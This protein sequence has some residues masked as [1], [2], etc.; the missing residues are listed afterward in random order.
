MVRPYDTRPIRLISPVRRSS[1]WGEISNSMTLE[2]KL[3]DF[4]R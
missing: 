2:R 1:F 4:G 3:N